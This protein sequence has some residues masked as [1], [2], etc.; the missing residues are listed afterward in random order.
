MDASQITV[1]P[2]DYRPRVR[3]AWSIR[4]AAG[5][6]WGP[7]RIPDFE[8]IHVAEGRLRV[9]VPEGDFVAEPGGVVTLYP[10]EMHRLV[11]DSEGGRLDC[12][13]AEFVRDLTWSSGGYRPQPWPERYTAVDAELPGLF[14]RCTRTFTG[15]EPRR[16]LLCET[17]AREL[18]IRLAVRWE[19][20]SCGVFPERMHGM[21]QY[22]REHCTERIGRDDLAARFHVTP[23]YVN[24]LF[25]RHLGMTPTELVHR[26]RIARAFDVLQREEGSVKE[27]AY[28]VGFSDPYYFSRV[29][30]KVYGVAP[31][32]VRP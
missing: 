4:P 28:A 1:S 32:E 18:M 25:R 26:E 14:H 6:S 11:M 23:Q 8:F 3:I 10:Q 5:T 21:M 29:F 30:K 16:M 15:T 24:Q 20:G 9:D 22:V 13:H 2:E 31:S 27:A 17:I 7:R 19:R 12:V